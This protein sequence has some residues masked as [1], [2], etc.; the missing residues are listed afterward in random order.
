[1]V[2]IYSKVAFAKSARKNKRAA[3]HEKE[4]LFPAANE[5][6][7]LENGKTAL[8]VV[9]L[10][11]EF[12]RDG[13]IMQV[14]SA[15]PTLGANKRL[16]EFFR[17][18]GMPVVYTKVFSRYEN[19]RV[20]FI[21]ALRPEVLL[22]DKA[23]VPGHRRYFKDVRKRLDVTDIVEE[24]YPEEGD[25][26]VEKDLY[27]SFHGTSLD[28]LLRGLGIWYVV[29]TG[30]VT[31]VCVESTAKGAFSHGYFPVIVSDAVSTDV[32]ESYITDIYTHFKRHWGRVMMSDD[33]I[34]ELSCQI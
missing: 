8:V 22:R 17:R 11:N 27:D 13:G 34:K 30:T 7:S 1:M 32:P 31:N 3:L 14:K 23:L 12:V 2:K 5:P 18:E 33:V 20:R 16:I 28:L 4:P 25:Y 6:F 29:V 15:K 21:K 26:I 24:I 10:V 9:D 19:I